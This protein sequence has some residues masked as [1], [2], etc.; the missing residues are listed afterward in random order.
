MLGPTEKPAARLDLRLEPT[1]QGPK[2]ATASP[3]YLP[4]KPV[5]TTGF[6][7]ACAAT[8][9][10]SPAASRHPAGGSKKPANGAGSW[11]CQTAICSWGAPWW[12]SHTKLK[13]T[14]STI[15]VMMAPRVTCPVIGKLAASRVTTPAPDSACPRARLPRCPPDPGRARWHRRWRSD[16]ECRCQ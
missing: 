14:I 3:G 13:A 8:P 7:F 9:F 5:I 11:P 2:P 12:R 1:V 6:F 4:K 15:T 10:H 16:R